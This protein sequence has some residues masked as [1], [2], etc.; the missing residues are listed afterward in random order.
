LAVA[1]FTFAQPEIG[2]F[3]GMLALD[4]A[5]PL[6]E[7]KMHLY[8]PPDHPK[9]PW[10]GIFTGLMLQH[11]FNFST[12]QFLVQRTLAAASDEDAR[13][14]IIASGFLK[15]SVPF[16]SIATGVA[17][18]YLFEARFGG[19]DFNSD[20]AFLKLVETVVPHG[21]GL[22]G[23]ILAGLTAATFSSVD[24]MMNAATTL[25]TVDV[26]QKYLNKTASDRQIVAFGRL[27]VLMLVIAAAGVAWLTFT[28]DRSNNFFLRVSAQ[29]SYFTP[30]IMAAFFFGVLWPRA[31]ARGAVAAMILA[32]VFG[33][34]AEFAWEALSGVPLNFLHR[35]ALTFIFSSTTILLLSEKEP[36]AD[37]Q[38]G[39]LR[40][41]LSAAVFARPLI[42]FA[43]LQL[44]ALSAVFFLGWSPEQS[45]PIG[46]AG[47]FA[48]FVPY[49]VKRDRPVLN[50]D[51]FYGGLLAAC[52]IWIYYYFA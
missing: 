10:T 47:A 27:T 31:G 42:I 12:N 7:Q 28:P 8:L 26:Y 16:F 40:I 13:K 5:R 14:G 48:V 37:G 36:F 51:L 22:T 41:G 1:F 6:T 49:L 23:L 25:L 29:L 9:L 34:S 32:P 33:L 4:A 44:P 24:S 20:N 35:I 2:G 3:D 45:A 18:Y 46:A 11:C 50:D 19:G 52:S 43:L 17:A 39:Q 21:I 15:L 38:N 30:G